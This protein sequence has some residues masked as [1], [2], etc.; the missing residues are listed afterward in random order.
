MIFWCNL[1]ATRAGIDQI[2]GNNKDDCGQVASLSPNEARS[3]AV[4]VGQVEF[5]RLGN[6]VP[7]KD[8]G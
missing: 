1:G 3:G 2:Q 8:S 5:E 4:S 7:P 6:A